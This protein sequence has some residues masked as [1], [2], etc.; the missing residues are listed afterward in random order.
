MGQSGRDRTVTLPCLWTG[1]PR[2]DGSP[3]WYVRRKGKDGATY[4]ALPDLPIDHPDFLSAY[5]AAMRDT[6]PEPQNRPVS[7]FKA[8]MRDAIASQRYKRL[9]ASYRRGLRR[10][11]EMMADAYDG[12]PLGK[13]EPRHVARDIEK[14]ENPGLR[15]K[16]WRFLGPL[17]PHD[18]TRAVRAQTQKGSGHEHWTPEEIAAFRARWAVGTAPR[19]AFELLLWSACRISD[20]V[21]IGLGNVGADGIMSYRQKKTGNTAFVPWSCQMPHYAAAWYG[22]RQGAM[23]AIAPFAGHMTFLATSQGRG[24]SDKALGTMIREAAK[25]AG[26]SGKS[27]HGLRTTR[28]KLLADAGATTHQIAAWSGHKTLKEVEHYTRDA[29]RRK[30]VMG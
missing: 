10:E 17:L 15:L 25:E 29:D 16:A 27:A 4:T 7:G 30:A 2:A 13:L 21:R 19:A 28:I 11:W 12:L 22:E 14:S 8:I 18:P 23:E 6:A 9:S 3:R 5:A 24:R 20:V 26:I 1:K